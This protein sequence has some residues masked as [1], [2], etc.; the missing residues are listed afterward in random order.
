MAYLPHKNSQPSITSSLNLFNAENVNVSVKHGYYEQFYPQQS[1]SKDIHFQIFSN[2]DYF[3]G[4]V[5]HI[6]RLTCG[7]Q[8]I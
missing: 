7:S 3:V 4:Y 1:L 6:Y 5:F 2:E 8:E